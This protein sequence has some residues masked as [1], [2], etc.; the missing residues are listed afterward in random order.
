MALAML[1]ILIALMHTRRL[2]RICIA[3]TLVLGAG[4]DSDGSTVPVP[5]GRVELDAVR[6]FHDF[7]LYWLGRSFD[8]LPLSSAEDPRKQIRDR[9]AVGHRATVTFDYGNC[10][11]TESAEGCAPPLV[12]TSEPGHRAE[13]YDGAAEPISAL[14]APGRMIAF[15]QETYTIE[16]YTGRVIIGIEGGSRRQVRDAVAA[17]RRANPPGPV[18]RRLPP[19]RFEHHLATP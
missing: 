1:P 2:G 17:L 10:E 16:I 6:R 12:V 8:G 11:V 18:L 19:P 13:R 5:K 7:P 15:G 9:R 3:A 4:C 14:G